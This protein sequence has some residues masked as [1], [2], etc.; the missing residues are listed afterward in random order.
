MEGDC[1]FCAKRR[2][3]GASACGA[4]RGGGD[5]SQ[6]ATR[7]NFRRHFDGIPGNIRLVC[8]GQQGSIF[9][10]ETCAKSEMYCWLKFYC[11]YLFVLLC[12]TF[13]FRRET[14]EVR[15]KSISNVCNGKNSNCKLLIL[16]HVGCKFYTSEWKELKLSGHDWDHAKD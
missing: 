3:G 1:N 12:H 13:F 7:S 9:W 4:G 2:A 5:G 8:K 10:S 15:H 6:R 16:Q 14:H 11:F